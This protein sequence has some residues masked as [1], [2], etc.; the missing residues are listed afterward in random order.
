MVYLVPNRGLFPNYERN[1]STLYNN[2]K[3]TLIHRYIVVLQYTEHDC[4]LLK[5]KHYERNQST[6]YN[7]HKT[8]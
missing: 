7:N 1:Q 6:L 3:H 4:F 5:P 8:L 2:H